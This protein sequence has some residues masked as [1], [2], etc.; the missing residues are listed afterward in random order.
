[1]SSDIADGIFREPEKMDTLLEGRWRRTAIAVCYFSIV[2]TLA[3]GITLFGKFCE[4][5]DTR[6]IYTMATF[7]M[8]IHSLDR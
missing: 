3:L 6:Y 4:T 1:M 7:A 8:F 5:N 2:S